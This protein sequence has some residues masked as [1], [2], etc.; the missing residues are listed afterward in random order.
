M[1]HKAQQTYTWQTEQNEW[2]RRSDKLNKTAFFAFMF[3]A[4][5]L[6]VASTTNLFDL[7]P[8]QEHNPSQDPAGEEKGESQTWREQKQVSI[9]LQFQSLIYYLISE[10]SPGFW[11]PHQM[12][13]G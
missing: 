12:T 4:L 13:D 7:W 2:E 3:H 5:I 1:V 6:P 8:L 9:A 10:P 11:L